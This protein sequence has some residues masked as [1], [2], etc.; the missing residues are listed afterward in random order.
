MA[1]PELQY[2][3]LHL[4]TYSYDKHFNNTLQ[5]FKFL[6]YTFHR[7]CDGFWILSHF[8]FIIACFAE[9]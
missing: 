6:L 2:V 8:H 4:K 9:C 1:H 7:L 5:V 3:L